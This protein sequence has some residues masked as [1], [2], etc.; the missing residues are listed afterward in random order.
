MAWAPGL[1]VRALVGGADDRLSVFAY[2]S[3]PRAAPQL[4]I[5]AFFA[6]AA[7]QLPQGTLVLLRRLAVHKSF[8][9]AIEVASG[10]DGGLVFSA[11]HDG[12][13][14]AW[15]LAKLCAPA[16]APPGPEPSPLF[17]FSTQA[18]PIDRLVYCPEHA[19]DRTVGGPGIAELLQTAQLLVLSV[20]P[21]STLAVACVDAPSRPPRRRGG[22]TVPCPSGTDFLRGCWERWAPGRCRWWPTRP[23]PSPSPI[24]PRGLQNANVLR[25]GR[26]RRLLRPRRPPPPQSWGQCIG[27]VQ[28]RCRTP[29][30]RRW[31]TLARAAGVECGWW[32][33]RSGGRAMRSCGCR[34]RAAI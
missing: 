9:S 13:V 24:R 6:G 8:V 17:A 34:G 5:R 14:C 10:A 7:G 11:G 31:W 16:T 27:A 30:H 28:C 19:W 33:G 15:D 12:L 32:P 18:V 21:S 3:A 20:Q 26:P 29:G 1:P 4:G 25:G 23:S 2:D 22:V